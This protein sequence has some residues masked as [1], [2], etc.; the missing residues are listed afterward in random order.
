MR[1]FAVLLGATAPSVAAALAAFF[2]GLGLGSFL[3]GRFASRLSP[4]LRVFAILEI[5][6]GVSALAVNPLI[7]ALRP[8][9]ASTY[10]TSLDSAGL[11]L[12]MKMIVAI[13]AVVVPAACMGGTL[14]MLSQFVAA[15]GH[16]LGVRAGGLYAVNT[17]GA[18]CGALAVPVL[19]LPGF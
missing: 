12:T 8:L 2:F 9:Y 18:A 4:P 14:P 10:D 1:R 7:D 16:A 3:L 5:A 15:R 13:V 17:L 11:Q 19:L 6:T